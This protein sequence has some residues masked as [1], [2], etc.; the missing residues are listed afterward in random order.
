[1]DIK[2]LRYFVEI[3][4]NKSFSKAASKLYITQQGLSL[5]ISR[6]ETELSCKLFKRSPKELTLTPQGEF[7]L[8]R[9]REII[10]KF[11]ECLDYFESAGKCT[12]VINVGAA[13]GAVPEFVGR[14]IF[15]FQRDYPQYQIEISEYP[16]LLCDEAVENDKVELGFSVGPID[17]NKFQG[18]LVF[19]ETGCLLVQKTHPLAK[20]ESISVKELKD[21][22]LMIMNEDSK[23]FHAFNDCCKKHG[24]TPEIK[25]RAAEVFAIHRFVNANEGI[26]ISIMSVAEEIGL[27]NVV[28]VPL[29]DEDMIWKIYLIQKKGE[30]L[31]YPARVFSKYVLEKIKDINEEKM[32]KI[33]E[34]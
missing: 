30:L 29:K 13:Y 21:K 32:L 4:N 3:Y 27:Y 31:S 24:F 16:D 7:L 23:T 12:E 14:I 2:Q 9:A 17:Q 11:D 15:E 28:A 20:R 5:S 19:S 1:L 33:C 6:L 25:Y 34:K 26:G 10:K 8:P 22:P 18:H